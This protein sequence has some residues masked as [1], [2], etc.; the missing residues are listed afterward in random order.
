MSFC[1]HVCLFGCLLV[2]AKEN[3]LFVFYRNPG[4]SVV[5]SLDTPIDPYPDSINPYP[6][7]E[8][9]CRQAL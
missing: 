7:F 6:D 3:D 8:G 2:C 5:R 1:L 4:V 9:L